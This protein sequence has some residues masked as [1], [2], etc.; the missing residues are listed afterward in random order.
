MKNIARMRDKITFKNFTDV[1]VKPT[2]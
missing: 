1:F 2:P